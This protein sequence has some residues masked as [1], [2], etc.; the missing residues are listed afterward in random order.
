MKPEYEH[1]PYRPGVGLLIL[2]KDSDVFVGERFEQPGFWQLPQGG[3]DDEDEA[4]EKSVFRELEEETG[5]ER[6]E[7]IGIM[8][9]WQHYDLPDHLIAKLWESRYRGQKQKW[10]A[11]RFNG[12]DSEINLHTCRYPEFQAWKWMSPQAA[13]NTV[14]RVKRDTYEKVFRHFEII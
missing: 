3:I 10:V 8:P 13:L 12:F 9:E 11:L 6:A 2:N 4:F 5:I 14:V 7:I 1:L